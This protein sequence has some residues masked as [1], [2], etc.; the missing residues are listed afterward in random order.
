MPLQPHNASF[1]LILIV[2]ASP[3]L[4]VKSLTIWLKS[5]IPILNF[6]LRVFN[7]ALLLSA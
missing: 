7:W 3:F 4:C 6:Y 2:K 1:R 5:H